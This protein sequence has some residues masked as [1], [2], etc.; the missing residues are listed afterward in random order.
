ME[1]VSPEIHDRM[2]ART[3]HLPHLLAA[4]LASTV[5]REQPARLTR[6]CGPGFMD[7]TRIAEG[8]PDIWLGI[9]ASNRRAILDELR[10]I[11][12]GMT[13]LVRSMER[14]DFV[15]VKRFLNQGRMRRRR[16]IKQ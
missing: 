8:S 11:Q 2:L 16:L 1:S 15:A 7:A 5:G 13:S 4:L 9:I 14:S 12:A 10:V 6:F 3:S